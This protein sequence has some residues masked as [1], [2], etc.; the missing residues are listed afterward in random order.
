MVDAILDSGIAFTLFLQGLGDWLVSPMEF[1]TFLGTE[2]F[3]IF[4]MPAIVWSIDS[5]LGIRIGVI[6]LLSSSVNTLLK[7]A[8]HLPRPYWYEAEVKGLSGEASFGVPSGHS[9]LPASIYGL[10]ATS[11]KRSWVWPAALSLI[12]LIGLSRMVLGVHFY[13]DVLVGWTVGFSILWAFL[14]LEAPVKSWLQAKPLSQQI[15]A[16]FTVSLAL[17]L[18]GILILG[19][20]GDYQPLPEW[21][22]NA[23]DDQPLTSIEPL[24]PNDII[25]SPA[26][27]FGLA[28]GAMWLAKRGWFNSKG[29]LGQ[30]LARFVIGL[31]GLLIFYLGLGAVFPREA[32]L[33]SYSLRYLRYSLIGFWIAGLAPVI[34]IKMGLAETE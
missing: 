26:A 18:I 15:G 20:I 23:R 34:F 14:R 9:Q 30:R 27:F 25:T 19:I 7:W 24:D 21:V 28:A 6:L 4:V 2:Q 31:G 3:Y 16:V 22:Q 10:I 8:F 11:V 29:T 32:D 12:F 17:I 13:L 5:R 1:F 33:L